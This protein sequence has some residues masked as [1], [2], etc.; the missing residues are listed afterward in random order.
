M[1]RMFYTPQ[2]TSEPYLLNFVDTPGHVDFAS[3]VY[4]SLL[5]VQGALLLVDATQGVQAQ[6]LVST[7]LPG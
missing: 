4:R 2:G 6:T 3:E 1:H 5:A 7:K